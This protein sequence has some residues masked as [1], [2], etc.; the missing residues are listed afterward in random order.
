MPLRGLSVPRSGAAS[1]YPEVGPQ[2]SPELADFPPASLP[3]VAQLPFASHERQRLFQEDPSSDPSRFIDN[4][5]FSP[6]T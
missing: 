4:K 1:F 5:G 2:V 3:A 6:A